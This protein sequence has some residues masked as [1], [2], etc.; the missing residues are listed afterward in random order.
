MKS[1]VT[2][3]VRTIAD[4]LGIFGATACALHCVAIPTLLVLGAAV[5]TVILGDESFHQWMLWL[6]VP[7]AVLAFSI[8][9]WRHRDRRVLLLATL[10]VAGLVISG[11]VLHDILGEAAEKVGTLGSAA[12][13]ITAHLR[14]FKLCRAE[15][16]L[17]QE[18][19][20]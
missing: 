15:S 1:P 8:G 4:G 16:C 12:L 19:E 6:V 18:E 7:A 14:N 17:C 13:L 11:T 20:A 2:L 10:G 5:P 3:N 9:C